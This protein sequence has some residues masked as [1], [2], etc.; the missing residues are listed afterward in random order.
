MKRATLIVL[1]ATLCLML[2]LG[3]GGH[4]K[5][6]LTP[7]TSV[8]AAMGHAEITHDKNGNTLVDLKVHHLAKPENLTPPASAYVVWFQP[9]GQPPQ[10]QGVLRV[11]SDLNGEFKTTTP[12]KNFD[13]F[14]TAEP[15]PTVTAPTGSEIMRQHVSG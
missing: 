2:E 3:C 13:I 9:A 5:V 1:A 8:P 12:L 7:A 11:D 6:D 14:V 15:G 4:K 10:N